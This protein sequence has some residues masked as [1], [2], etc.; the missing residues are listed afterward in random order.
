MCQAT[1]VATRTALNSYGFEVMQAE[2]ALSHPVKG[3][4]TVVV[5]HVDPRDG[6]DPTGVFWGETLNGTAACASYEDYEAY[7]ANREWFSAVMSDGELLSDMG[8]DL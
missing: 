1:L 2:Y 5:S 7:T 6:C 8:V 3:F 4:T